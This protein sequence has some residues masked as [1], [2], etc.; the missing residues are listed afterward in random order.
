MLATDSIYRLAAKMSNLPPSACSADPQAPAL[1]G[2]EAGQLDLQ[3]TTATGIDATLYVA[4]ENGTPLTDLA[5]GYHVDLHIYSP[6]SDTRPTTPASSP[7]SSLL[8]LASDLE[9]PKLRLTLEG[10]AINVRLDAD[11]VGALDPIEMAS[12]G[13]QIFIRP[14]ANPA[15]RTLISTGRASLVTSSM[16]T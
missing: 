16:V 9:D 14:A 4:D 13:I 2:A 12:G 6:A 10:S 3:L 7:V 1:I 11:D 15:Q 5:A 8:Y